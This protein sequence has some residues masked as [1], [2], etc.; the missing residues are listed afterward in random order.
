MSQGESLHPL[1]QLVNEHLN[2]AREA[3]LHRVRGNPD[4]LKKGMLSFCSNDYLS[5]ST[6]LALQ[7]AYQEGFKRYPCGSGGS[8]VISGYH[9]THRMLEET[10]AKALG[11]DDALL[12][13]SGYAANLAITALLATLNTPI[14]L[15]KQVHASW[16]DGLKAT[17]ARVLRY[18]H[19]DLDHLET[20][21]AHAARYSPSACVIT[22]GLFSMSGQVAPMDAI[23]SLCSQ[24][25]AL[26]FVDEAHS[27]GV[28][29]P[30][31]LGVVNQYALTTEDVPLR[32]IAFGKALAGQG[33]VV[34]GKKAWI[35]ALL[36]HA[37]SYIY[38][39]AI[40]PALAHGML[41][42]FDVVL[43]ANDRRAKL[44]DLVRYFQVQ[45]NNSALSWRQ[46]ASPI[47]Q[48][49]LGCPHRAKRVTKHLLAQGIYCQ[50][51]RQPTVT[52]KET[53]LRVVL[54]YDH[55]H[56]DLDRLFQALSDYY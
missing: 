14:L 55:T 7:Q 2:T 46:S 5:L 6:H 18:R 22:E 15:D 36:Q 27:F 23:V 49:Q 24:Y 45:C 35:D 38:S 48:L 13:S 40:S 12:F 34:V 11:A 20:Q 41:A 16:Y 53:G 52:L 9:A 37:R 25:K 26:C 47:Q 50:P 10:V 44:Y 31:G 33:A 30:N 29:G 8:A 19:Q 56:S 43:K 54:N 39:T 1:H 3:G 51:I 42:A 28:I 32:L 21:L 17:N 4:F